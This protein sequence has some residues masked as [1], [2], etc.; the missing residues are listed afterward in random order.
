MHGES[1]SEIIATVVRKGSFGFNF[2][3]VV[4]LSIHSL[5]F[6]SYSTS[7]G[8]GSH[9]ASSSALVLQSM[10]YAELT[11]SSMKTL[12]LHLSYIIQILL[13]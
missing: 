6:A 12:A 5:A 13:L 2:T 10:H 3:N 7:W 11:V 1:S 8:Y 4:Y 9:Q